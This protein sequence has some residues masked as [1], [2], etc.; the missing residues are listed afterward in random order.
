MNRL[1]DGPFHYRAPEEGAASGGAA[2]EGQPQAGETVKNDTPDEG[3]AK[4]EGEGAKPKRTVEDLE[5]ELAETR[6][7]A[8]KNRV[9]A[10]ELEEAER[11]RK[12]AELGDV[13]RAN[14]QLAEANERATKAEREARDARAEAI[15]SRLG[16]ADGADVVRLLD[17]GKVED[18]L[19]PKQ[20]EAA[21]AA[22]LKAK[23]YL[24]A[25]SGLPK[26]EGGN[27]PGG[28][29]GQTAREEL[30]KRYPILARRERSGT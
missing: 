4:A 7:E 24:K 28:A 11:K 13:E 14:K 6:R 5:A 30:S 25:Q 2:T 17:W 23:P 19:D 12:D 3:K 9:R 20:I 26:S 22:L 21:I 16:A 15:A 8:A 10:K 29:G 27:A 1:S 18:P